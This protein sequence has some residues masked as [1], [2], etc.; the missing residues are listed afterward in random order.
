MSKAL[1]D[2]AVLKLIDAKL[3]L[4]GSVTTKD[5]IRHLGLSRQ[6]VSKVFQNYLA[7]NPNAMVYV[8]A[9]RK[10]IASESFKPCFL[11]ESKAGEFVDA[12]IVVFGTFE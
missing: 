9:K 10:Y 2:D 1:L 7:A 6:K 8:P 11:V 3:V 5:I 4:N 12:L